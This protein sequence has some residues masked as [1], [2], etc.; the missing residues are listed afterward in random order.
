MKNIAFLI[1]IKFNAKKENSKIKATKQIYEKKVDKIFMKS[2]P[3]KI[4]QL[5]RPSFTL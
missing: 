1:N 4:L 2:A 3:K 5:Y